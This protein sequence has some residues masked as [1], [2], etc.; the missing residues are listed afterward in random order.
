MLDED[1]MPEE[2]GNELNSSLRS[3]KFQE[4]DEELDLSND[5]ILEERRERN[6]IAQ[7]RKKIQELENALEE[8]SGHKML[9]VI[10]GPPDPDSI[11]SAW[12]HCFIAQNYGIETQIL[13]FDPI[14]H[15]ENRALVKALRV[16]LLQYNQDIDLSEFSCY[17]LVDTPSEDFPAMGNLPKDTPLFSLV[18]HHKK[19]GKVK[20]SFVD[21]RENAG[22]TSSI[23]AEYLQYGKCT[24]SATSATD[25]EL[26]TALHH[27]IRTDTDNFFLAREIDWRAA[28]YLSRFADRDLLRQ[29][30]SSPITG[31]T[32]D[33]LQQALESKEIKDNYLFAGV[34]F[35]RES[36]RDG[37]AQAADYL[38]RREGI[39]TAIV[40]GIVED[41]YIHGSL[42]TRSSTVDPD[43]FLKEVLGVDKET[44]RAYG[45]GRF[46]KGGFQ[47]PLS[48]FSD[49]VE[50]KLLWELVSKTIK[51]KFLKRLG[52]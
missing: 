2:Q 3:K 19:T 4:A 38:V 34:S 43:S 16:S 25:A 8:Y 46:D 30:A 47:I 21:I 6:N 24:L 15:A 35:V 17:A 49:C 29:I 37:I 33:I 12:A 51:A 13:Y 31:N 50:K 52:A 32:M 23:Y 40:F 48:I 36:D 39:D 14:S 10:K 5:D 1:K 44:G 20:A 22:A 42:R 11:A 28:A 45:G 26:A 7:Q 27:G 18:D 9:V 41:Q